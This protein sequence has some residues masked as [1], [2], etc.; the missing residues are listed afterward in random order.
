MRL[1]VGELSEAPLRSSTCTRL[2]SSAEVT[3]TRYC[4]ALIGG[5][6]SRQKASLP[7]RPSSFFTLA[8]GSA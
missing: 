3:A 8:S 6:S 5:L 7:S 4:S 2:A 1:A